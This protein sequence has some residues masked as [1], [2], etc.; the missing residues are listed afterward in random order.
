MP[1]AL[2]YTIIRTVAFAAW[3]VAGLDLSPAPI[4]LSGNA[5]LYVIALGCV[6]SYAC[7][8]RA[9]ARPA[10]EVFEAGKAIG[11]R[12]AMLEQE[13]ENVRR[14]GERPR[15]NVVGGD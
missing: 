8:A 3:I 4:S 10:D 7:I 14:I 6:C 12:E 1:R 13:C 11:R 5:A 2:T 15:L 9:H